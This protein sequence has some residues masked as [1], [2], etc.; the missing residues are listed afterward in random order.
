M[1]TPF[2]KN[3]LKQLFKKESNLSTDKKVQT[4]TNIIIQTA[5]MSVGIKN[6]K[7]RKIHRTILPKWFDND[8]FYFKR[9]IRFLTKR[10]LANTFDVKIKEELFVA[11]KQYKKLNK[12]KKK[13]FKEDILEKII[14]GHDNNPQEYWNLIKQLR[15]DECDSNKSD[16]ADNLN[17]VERVHYFQ[18]LLNKKS[19]EVSDQE[20]VEEIRLREGRNMFNELDYSIKEKEIR[21]VIIDLKPNKSVCLDSIKK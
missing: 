11:K 3:D 4:L 1:E 19:D 13:K 5:K 9:K 12:R 2:V 8:C 18:K 6:T 7:Y 10:F 14:K 17:P 21:V 16:P 15:N 20:I